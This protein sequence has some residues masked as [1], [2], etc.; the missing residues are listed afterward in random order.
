M[1]LRLL[2]SLIEN[3]VH[4]CYVKD[5]SMSHTERD[6]GDPS[7]PETM[8]GFDKFGVNGNGLLSITYG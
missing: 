6:A 8:I 3:T 4:A 7:L 2:C 5:G 1:R